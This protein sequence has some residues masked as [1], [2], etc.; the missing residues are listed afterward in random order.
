ME[1]T[2]STW[3]ERAWSARDCQLAPMATQTPAGPAAAVVEVEAV[4][5]PAAV[6][7]FA[8]AQH[9][10]AAQHAVSANDTVS[11]QPAAAERDCHACRSMG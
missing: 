1:L 3:L 5:T 7:P 10:R 4:E 8:R 6:D 2:G 9:A 11:R